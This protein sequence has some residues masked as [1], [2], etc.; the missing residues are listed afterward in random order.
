[1][2]PP[3]PPV[4]FN[5]DP[6]DTWLSKS[7]STVAQSSITSGEADSVQWQ[8]GRA[9]RI[10]QLE[11]V[12]AATTQRRCQ[13]QKQK[14]KKSVYNETNYGDMLDG[15][16]GDN[17]NCAAKISGDGSDDDCRSESS[18]LFYSEGRS[19]LCT[20]YQPPAEPAADTAATF[21]VYGSVSAPEPPLKTTEQFLP[22]DVRLRDAVRRVL[23]CGRSACLDSNN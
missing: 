14:Q 5:V 2:A 8:S 6:S 18:S 4:M 19:L 12:L 3:Q 16:D 13:G 15:E 17:S 10:Q 21:G 23:Y 20:Y 9:E 7:S 1:M 22:W 11:S